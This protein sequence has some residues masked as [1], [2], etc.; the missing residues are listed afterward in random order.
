MLEETMIDLQKQ[1][2][3]I[4]PK[5]NENVA[6]A[7]FK[8][9]KAVS[10]QVAD[11]KKMR[12]RRAANMIER[13]FICHAQSCGKAYGSE[14]SLNQHIKNKHSELRKEKK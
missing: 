1:Q 6:E 8:M 10:R 12:V 11:S 2:K 3:K 7:A 4:Q 5:T 9:P 14:G 13:R